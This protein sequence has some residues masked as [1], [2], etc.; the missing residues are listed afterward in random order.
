MSISICAELV[1]HSLH[2]SSTYVFIM[3]ISPHISLPR[4]RDKIRDWWWA[5][6]VISQHCHYTSK[7]I[8]MKRRGFR[9]RYAFFLRPSG[10]PT[11]AYYLAYLHHFTAHLSIYYDLVLKAL[12]SEMMYM[13]SERYYILTNHSFEQNG[14]RNNFYHA[15]A[16]I[17]LIADACHKVD[18]KFYGDL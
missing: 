1:P 7:N 16:Y 11:A 6:F 12:T 2:T 18:E 5:A 9:E 4:M 15:Y 10:T 3:I 8:F 14:T 13:L 17:W